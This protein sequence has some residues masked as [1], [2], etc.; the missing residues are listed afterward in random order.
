MKIVLVGY[1]GSGKSAV[2]KELAKR[3]KIQFY[4]P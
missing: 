1:M 4:R 2:G 3:L